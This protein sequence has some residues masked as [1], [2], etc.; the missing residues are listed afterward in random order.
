MLL[1]EAAEGKD[2]RSGGSHGCE[3]DDRSREGRFETQGQGVIMSGTRP[4]Q[5]KVVESRREAFEGPAVRGGAR[6][7]RR[8]GW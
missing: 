3:E 1:G 8:S 7:G 4:R 2:S 6:R 5:G